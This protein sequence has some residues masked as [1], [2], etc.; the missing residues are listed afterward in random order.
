MSLT[1]A[2]PVLTHWINRRRS[3]LNAAEIASRNGLP[4]L[5][6]LRDS[7]RCEARLNKLVRLIEKASLPR[8]YQGHNPVIKGRLEIAH[9]QAQLRSA[10]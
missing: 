10:A 5:Y 1:D 6:L 4:A 3:S 2:A 7:S 8:D 9:R